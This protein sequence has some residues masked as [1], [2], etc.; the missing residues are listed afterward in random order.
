[1]LK[2]EAL[3]PPASLSTSSST[4]K[5]AMTYNQSINMKRPIFTFH[6]Q[7]VNTQ[8][9]RRE[10]LQVEHKEQMK[11]VDQVYLKVSIV[12]R[13]ILYVIAIIFWCLCF[14]LKI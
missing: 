11:V 4:V 9:I 8:E 2:C 13:H 6:F 10:Q 12:T 5:T 3:R 7:L 1:M 14:K